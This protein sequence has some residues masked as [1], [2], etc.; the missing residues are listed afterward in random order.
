M[1]K[2]TFWSFK[3]IS[4]LC[5]CWHHL[6]PKSYSSNKHENPSLIFGPDLWIAFLLCAYYPRGHQLLY[7]QGS[8]YICLPYSLLPAAFFP[9]SRGWPIFVLYPEPLCSLL[10][11]DKEETIRDWTVSHCA[12][13]PLSGLQSLFWRTAVTTR[14]QAP[15]HSPAPLCVTLG[16][17]SSY[18]HI[19]WSLLSFVLPMAFIGHPHYGKCSSETL[20]YR[21]EERESMHTNKVA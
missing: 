8:H 21:D 14:D 6:V 19:F 5:T 16:P 20:K 1:A 11:M 10:Y 15:F 9:S 18:W 7:T 13:Q 17:P 3:W 2:S 4:S 12:H